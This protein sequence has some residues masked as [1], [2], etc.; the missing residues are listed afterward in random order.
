MLSSI[1][2]HYIQRT[3]NLCLYGIG[4]QKIN[5]KL[6][7]PQASIV[8]LINCKR[9]GINQF[10]KPE[11]FPN[12]KVIHYLSAHPGQID[13]YRRFNSSVSWVFPNRNYIFYECMMEAGLGHI[14]PTLI[15]RYICRVHMSTGKRMEADL[16]LPELGVYKSSYYRVQ[17]SRYLSEPYHPK[18]HN[19]LL[20]DTLFTGLAS[21]DLCET[22]STTSK[23]SLQHYQDERVS[24]EFFEGLMLDS[25]NDESNK[26][27]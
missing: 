27:M 11:I 8:T 24:N 13:L 21:P 19:Y 18:Q 15:R 16:L 3:K 12:V 22:P 20:L 17:L 5:S 10:L 26:N 4:E 7:F 25:K 23:T 9:E 1:F 6:I 14:D 2:H